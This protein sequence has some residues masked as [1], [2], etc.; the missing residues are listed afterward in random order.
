MERLVGLIKGKLRAKYMRARDKLQGA[1]LFRLQHF[2][3]FDAVG[4]ACAVVG[5]VTCAGIMRKNIWYHIE[6][7]L[8]LQA[9][10]ISAAVALPEALKA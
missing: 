2:F 3:F 1:E 4:N 5:P 9:V 8:A 10:S 6:L 7:G